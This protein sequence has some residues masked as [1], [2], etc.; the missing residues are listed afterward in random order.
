MSSDYL[1]YE[2][3]AE[4]HRL[5]VVFEKPT[6]WWNYAMEGPYEYHWVLHPHKLSMH[7]WDE[8]RENIYPVPAPTLSSILDKLVELSKYFKLGASKVKP[9]LLLLDRD[10]YAEDQC[11]T[12]ACGQALVELVKGEKG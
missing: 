8:Y 9:Y 2:L 4:L 12:T 3:S 6:M 1:N 7:K 10:V 5:G 11:C